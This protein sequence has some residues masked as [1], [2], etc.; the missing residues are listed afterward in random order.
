MSRAIS[1]KR[2]SV[3][4]AM[5]TVLFGA[6]NSG[7]GDTANASPILTVRDSFD[8]GLAALAPGRLT[9]RD[10][11]VFVVTDNLTRVVV[12]PTGTRLVSA[13]DALELADGRTLPNG[14]SLEIDGGSVP[15]AEALTT[16]ASDPS[17]EAEACAERADLFPTVFVAGSDPSA[18]RV[19]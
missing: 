8:G 14:A 3:A 18:V 1:I 19:L 6:C 5:V 4:A 7:G 2:R 9:I 16:F 15:Y 17:S 12:W 11:C 10:G 13:E